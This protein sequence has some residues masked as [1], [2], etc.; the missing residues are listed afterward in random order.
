MPAANQTEEKRER[1]SYEL[2]KIHFT[3]FY[4]RGW[5][6]VELT[7][8]TERHYETDATDGYMGHRPHDH[9]CY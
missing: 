8:N 1:A 6:Q 9:K 4:N 5:T 3:T 2:D 7:T